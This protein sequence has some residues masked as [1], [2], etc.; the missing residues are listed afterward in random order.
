M[1]SKDDSCN[2]NVKFDLNSASVNNS[3]GLR[4][5]EVRRKRQLSLSVPR[6]F[7]FFF[8]FFLELDKLIPAPEF[9]NSRQNN[10]V[11]YF[12]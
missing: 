10:K 3:N 6:W 9:Y 12:D 7:L 4:D 2:S 11:R 5:G 8:F 1:F